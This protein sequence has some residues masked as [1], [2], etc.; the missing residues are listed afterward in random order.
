MKARSAFAI[1]KD[2]IFAI[3]VREMNSRF[4]AYTFGN[5]WLV[6]EPLLMMVMFILIFGLRGR[7]EFGYVDPPIFVF[8]AFLP[9]K[10]LWQL[11]M[12]RNMGALQGAKSLMGF[13]QVRLFDVFLTR[14]LMEGGLFIVVGVILGIGLYW[15]G[16][17]PMPRDPLLVLSYGVILWFFASAM[18]ILFCMIG[19]F[20]KEVEKVLNMVQMPLLFLSAVFFPMTMVPEPYRSWLAWNP[21]VHAM[22]LVREAW[23]PVYI[24]PVADISYLASWAIV[25]MALAMATYRLSWQK[26][27]A[28]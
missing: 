6:L 24:S 19:Q 15:I 8:A 7:G 28:I 20:A 2:V 13:R 17:N 23:F 12:R 18:G 26:V 4:G 1:Q 10:I 21:L 14:S 11:T 5:V 3:F 22:E 9:F 16:F 25:A 27:L